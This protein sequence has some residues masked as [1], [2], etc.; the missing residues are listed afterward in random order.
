MYFKK[1][2]LLSIFLCSVVP[3]EARLVAVFNEKYNQEQ[4][5]LLTKLLKVAL[6]IEKVDSLPLYIDEQNKIKDILP[7]DIVLYVIGTS[8]IHD[9]KVLRDYIHDEKVLRNY[10]FD[11]ELYGTVTQKTPHVVIVGIDF[12]SPAPDFDEHIISENPQSGIFLGHSKEQKM[13]IRL[14]AQQIII[15]GSL[16]PYFPLSSWNKENLT[17]LGSVI[18]QIIPTKNMVPQ[19]TSNAGPSSQEN[20]AIMKA[21]NLAKSSEKK[22]MAPYTLQETSFLKDQSQSP[23]RAAEPNAHT[24]LRSIQL[25]LQDLARTTN[26]N[27]ADKQ[28]VD[29]LLGVFAAQA[30][31]SQPKVSE[32]SQLPASRPVPTL[33]PAKDLPFTRANAKAQF[34]LDNYLQQRP[35][36]RKLEEPIREAVKDK[37]FEIHRAGK[38][39]TQEA[40]S[41]AINETDK[42]FQLFFEE[43]P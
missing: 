15:E 30:G 22:K 8:Y 11:K 35:R 33:A 17:K 23:L 3:A 39:I 34:Q 27:P 29:N 20:Q 12:E 24:I 5:N 14:V 19:A 16:I 18:R 6:I 37:L 9:G 10:F 42:E 40:I 4:K 41:Q 28:I 26:L 32:Q 1:L 13:I 2:I 43:I 31:P 36:A 25:Q 7:E 21:S 38:K